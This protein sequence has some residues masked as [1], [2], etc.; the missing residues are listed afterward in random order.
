[1]SLLPHPATCG[2]VWDS[3]CGIFI[4][5]AKFVNFRRSSGQVPSTLASFGGTRGKFQDHCQRNFYS[6]QQGRKSSVSYGSQRINYEEKVY[7]FFSV[8]EFLQCFN[9]VMMVNYFPSLTHCLSF[10]FYAP[11]HH[12]S[13]PFSKQTLKIHFSDERQKA[14]PFNCMV[15]YIYRCSSLRNKLQMLI[16]KQRERF[17]RYKH[18]EKYLHQLCVCGTLMK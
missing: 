12:V 16:V 5:N 15:F 11:A 4:Q 14:W 9:T 13:F 3:P 18:L 8:E 17:S 10:Y 2:E 1:M 7:I 6:W